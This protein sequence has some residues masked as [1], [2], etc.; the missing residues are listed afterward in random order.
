M[1]FLEREIENANFENITKMITQA[2]LTFGRLIGQT[3]LSKFIC[4]GIDSVNV[5]QGTRTKIT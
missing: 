1:V 5:F 3:L 2:L 4:F